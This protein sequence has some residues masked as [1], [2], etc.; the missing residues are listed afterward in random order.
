MLPTA[1]FAAGYLTEKLSLELLGSV[2]AHSQQTKFLYLGIAASLFPDV[3]I[4]FFFL[5]THG[6][7][8]GTQKG[9]NHRSYITHVPAFHLM[10]AAIAWTGSRIAGSTTGELIAIVY[11]IGTWTH[12]VT[13]SFFY[14]IRWLWPFS[15]RFYAVSSA[16]RDFEIRSSSALDFWKKF[17]VKYSHNYVFYLELILIAAAVYTYFK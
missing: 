12:F 4:L 5:Q 10:I 13:D 16:G 14:G 11:L 6:F 7:A 2:Y 9:I 15:N 8:V 3:D 17:L 1:H